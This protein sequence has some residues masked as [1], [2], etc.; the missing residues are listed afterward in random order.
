[1]SELEKRED[2]SQ[3]DRMTTEQLQEI[4][5]KHAHN[6]LEPEPDTQE[7]YKIMEVLSARR[8]A[9]NS[10]IFRSDEEAFAE[11]LEEYLP[12][13]KAKHSFLSGAYRAVA[14]VLALVLVFSAGFLFSAEASPTNGWN[15]FAL[16]NNEVFT[17]QTDPNATLPP[18]SKKI[19]PQLL[20]LHEA[21]KQHGIPDGFAPTWIPDGYV[22]ENLT[23]YDTPNRLLIDSGYQN[24]GNWL[25][26]RIKI[27][28]NPT[29]GNYQKDDRYFE[30]YTTKGRDYY[31][32]SNNANLNAVW[33]DGDYEGSLTFRG[34]VEE[35][36]AMVDSIY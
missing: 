30:I 10:S 29:P 17:F 9:E 26:I 33:I 1:M 13:K 22:F 8:K 20:P 2:F 4:L 19:H 35:L 25:L 24:N 6:E 14:A 28:Y 21:L 12:R 7:L 31:L 11:F 34:T 27:I 15:R 16:W 3:Y 5:R 32:F 36:K 18:N 23:A